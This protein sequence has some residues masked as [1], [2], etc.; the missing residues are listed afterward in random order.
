MTIFACAVDL[1]IPRE[2]TFLQNIK[3]AFEIL[4][5]DLHFSHVA[6]PIS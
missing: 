3:F 2:K 1:I 5:T 6:W 4:F